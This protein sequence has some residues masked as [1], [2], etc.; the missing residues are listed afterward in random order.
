VK[1]E[2]LRLEVH[3]PRATSD[4][5]QETLTSGVGRAWY[6]ESDCADS[7]D[8]ARSARRPELRVQAANE[9]KRRVQPEAHDIKTVIER[10]QGES[11]GRSERGLR[12]RYALK[13]TR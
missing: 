12:C 6:D 2:A 4:K 9:V 7:R 5:A 13:T 3:E 8:C 1:R 10:A 11:A